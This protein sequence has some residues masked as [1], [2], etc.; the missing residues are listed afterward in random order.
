MSFVQCRIPLRKLS[1]ELAL[2]ILSRHTYTDKH[3]KCFMHTDTYTQRQQ[4]CSREWTFLRAVSRCSFCSPL[5]PRDEGGGCFCGDFQPNWWQSFNEGNFIIFTVFLSPIAHMKRLCCHG[6]VC[7]CGMCD[8]CESVSVLWTVWWDDPVAGIVDME[9]KCFLINCCCKLDNRV[10]STEGYTL[11]EKIF[12][13][14]PKRS[15]L[16]FEERVLKWLIFP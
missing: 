11:K 12:K 5:L 6:D 1:H 14:I 13:R 7:P 9:T 10:K 3:S 2:I 15:P 16:L 4:G 8:L